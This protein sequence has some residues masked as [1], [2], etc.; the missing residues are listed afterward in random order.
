MKYFNKKVAFTSIDITAL[1][2][3][4]ST[5]L[6][7]AADISA[8]ADTITIEGHPY[9][10]GDRVSLGLTAGTGV[11]ATAP[12]LSIAYWVIYVD[13]DTVALATSLALAKAGTK[14]ALTAGAAA[15]AFLQRD[16][17]GLVTT[18]LIIPKGAVVTNCTLDIV[19]DFTSFDGTNI[20]KATI[21]LGISAA[22]D[23]VAAIA[24]ETGSIWDASRAGTLCGTP[25][26]GA[27]AG[28]G[29][30]AIELAAITA[31]KYIKTTADVALNY[32]VAV[33]TL[34]GGKMNV[35]VEYFEPQI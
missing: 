30:S 26:L 21:S 18:D 3:I 35:Y 6:F 14:T 29:D 8:A 5:Y 13:K 32:T 24:I 1:N 31:V 10:T 25:I 34:V 7:A 4:D 12:A 28:D 11:T 2:A 22:A 17:F 15:D 19:T 27:N 33:D 20:D 16:G 9:I 23:L